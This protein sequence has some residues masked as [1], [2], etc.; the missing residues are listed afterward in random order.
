MGPSWL[1]L[2]LFKLGLR[3]SCDTSAAVNRNH[4]LSDRWRKKRPAPYVCVSVC[5]ISLQLECVGEDASF[6]CCASVCSPAP[7]EHTDHM[8]S[9]VGRAA[10]LT[11]GER[12]FSSAHL[13]WLGS[14]S[15]R[16]ERETAKRW[17]DASS[18]SSAEQYSLKCQ[19]TQTYY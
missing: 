17:E 19:T 9:N 4:V 14:W 8:H 5:V 18:T 13:G 11:T 12:P 15:P 1:N 7:W 6:K 2:P 16:H 10:V 3:A